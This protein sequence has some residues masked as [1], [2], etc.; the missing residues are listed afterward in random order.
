MIADIVTADIVTADIVNMDIVAGDIVNVDIVTTIGI[1]AVSYIDGYVYVCSR[2]I[3]P[4]VMSK[5]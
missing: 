5:Y 4:L 3:G 1:L 2:D